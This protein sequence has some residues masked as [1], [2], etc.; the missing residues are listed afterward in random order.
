M[1]A[2]RGVLGNLLCKSAEVVEKRDA[3]QVGGTPAPRKGT[4][5]TRHSKDAV[6][7][8]GKKIEGAGALRLSA[9]FQLRREVFEASR[10]NLR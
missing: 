4:G 3:I 10:L 1:R 8:S 7:V 2:A 9:L 6:W 5:L